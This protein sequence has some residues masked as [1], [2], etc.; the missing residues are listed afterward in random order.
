M[1]NRITAAQHCHDHRASVPFLW[2]PGMLSKTLQPCLLQHTPPYRCDVFVSRHT[3]HLAHLSGVA[4]HLATG[5]HAHEHMHTNCYGAK[6]SDKRLAW[7]YPLRL[8]LPISLAG[9][10]NR[11][12]RYRALL[13]HHAMKHINDITHPPCACPPIPVPTYKSICPLIHHP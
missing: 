1:A 4:R 13:L 9:G 8:S 11:C 12:S 6:P 5:T 2:T 7:T 3:L 10:K